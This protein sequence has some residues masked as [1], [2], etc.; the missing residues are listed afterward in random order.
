MRVVAAFRRPN[1]AWLERRIDGPCIRSC[2]GPVHIRLAPD[3]LCGLIQ[4]PTDVI[5]WPRDR[6]GGILRDEERMNLIRR[7]SAR[8]AR[9][10]GGACRLVVDRTA[11]RLGEIL[12]WKYGLA[13]P[14]F[15]ELRPGATPSQRCSK[16]IR[17]T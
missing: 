8:Q 4:A 9:S 10:V 5:L 6:L 2:T 7:L 11:R 3:A 15:D 12:L 16:S 1:I 14:G 13:Q 17:L